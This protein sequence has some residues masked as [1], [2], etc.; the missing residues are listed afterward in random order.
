MFCLYR[1]LCSQHLAQTSHTECGICDQFH[2]LSMLSEHVEDFIP[3]NILLIWIEYFVSRSFVDGHWGVF[4]FGTE[5]VT[6][7]VYILGW[8]HVFILPEM[9]ADS[10]HNC[11]LNLLKNHQTGFQGSCVLVTFVP[12]MCAVLTSLHSCNSS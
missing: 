3:C 5:S 9:H 11:M 7:W 12:V 2:K 8:T 10:Y 1:L 6:I 4:C